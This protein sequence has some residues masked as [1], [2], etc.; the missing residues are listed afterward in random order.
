MQENSYLQAR[1]E[2]AR[3]T[4]RDGKTSPRPGVGKSLA[5]ALALLFF[6]VVFM[7]SYLLSFMV[8]PIWFLVSVMKNAIQRPG[9]G[10]ALLRISIPPLTLALVMANNSFQL[11]IADENAPLIIAA[12]ERFYTDN[13][14]YPMT[15][16]DLVP[17]YL[18]SI[19]RA[20]YCL[21]G[22]F[23]YWNCEEHPMLVWQVVGSCRKIYT[24]D[25]RRWSYLD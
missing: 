3:L 10:I 7:G 23:Q 13:S 9:W 14:K 16:D 19:P 22:E 1:N 15:L 12:C 5:G 17:R 24:F 18:P 20:K 6:D 2:D 25:D 4:I 11:N 21:G 8:C